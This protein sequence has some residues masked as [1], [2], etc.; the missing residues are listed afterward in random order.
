MSTDN[1]KSNTAWI[2]DELNLL[3]ESGLYTHIRTIDSPMDAWVTIDGRRVLNFC[4]NNYLG[5]A[6]HPRCVRQ[7][8]KPSTTT[9]SAPARCGPLPAR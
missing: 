1:G 7:P 3:R 9:A 8:K 5:L 4:A 6:N 2:A